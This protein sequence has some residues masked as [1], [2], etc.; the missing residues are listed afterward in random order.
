MKTCAYCKLEIVEANFFVVYLDGNEYSYHL[1]DVG[2]SK[3]GAC[4]IVNRAREVAGVL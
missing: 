4:K 1:D 3:A 2:C